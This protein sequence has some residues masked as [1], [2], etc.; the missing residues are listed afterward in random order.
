MSE[1]PLSELLALSL[2]ERAQLAAD[3]WDSVADEAEAHPDRLPV[4]QAQAREIMRRS[5]AYHQNPGRAVPLHE[6]LDR[7]E[8][9]LG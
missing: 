9:S 7:I 8:R 1:I 2:S 6:A 3:L 5:R 4:S